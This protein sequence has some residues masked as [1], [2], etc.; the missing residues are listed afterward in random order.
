MIS[1]ETQGIC[2]GRDEYV[3]RKDELGV[4]LDECAQKSDALLEQKSRILSQVTEA[5]VANLERDRLNVSE[6]NKKEEEMEGLDLRLSL[7]NQLTKINE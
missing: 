1:N 4:L 2:G 5:E 6:Y 7:E 3:E